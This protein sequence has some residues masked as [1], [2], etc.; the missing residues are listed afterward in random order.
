MIDET[1]LKNEERAV[2][3]LRSLYNRFGYRLYKMSK[4]EEYDFYARNKDFLIS[5]GILTFTDKAGKLLALKPDVTLSI[6]KNSKDGTKTLEKFYYNENVYRVTKGTHNFKEIMQTGL[7]CIGDVDLYASC[8]VLMLAVKSL[9][10]LHEECV[11]DLSHAGLLSALLNQVTDAPEVKSEL[12]EAIVRK[13][14]DV[15]SALLKEEK[16]SKEG[17]LLIKAL[18]AEY[19]DAEAMKAALCTFALSEESAASLDEFYEIVKSLE[20]LSLG[21]YLNISFSLPCSTSYYSGVV[22]QGYVKGIPDRVLSGGRYDGLMKKL[23]KRAGAIGFA[24]YLDNFE[25]FGEEEKPFDVDVLLLKEDGV[26]TEDVI[27]AVEKLS[28]DGSNVCVQ[29]LVPT[30]IRYRRAI[31]LGE[32]G[33][34]EL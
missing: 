14:A 5:D 12:S 9:V 26:K 32:K 28:E 3:S 16:I 27:A 2:Y 6:V 20:A 21:K 11:L 31:R 8:E 34:E 15:P 4:F 19:S 24:V 17:F 25:R 23:G 7:E 1:L 13:S 29:S 30:D 22:F 18:M 10:L 33:M